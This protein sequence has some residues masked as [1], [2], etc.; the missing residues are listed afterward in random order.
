MV[1]RVECD[2]SGWAFYGF[3]AIK[4][5]SDGLQRLSRDENTQLFEDW[6]RRLSAQADRWHTDGTSWVAWA[7]PSENVALHKPTGWLA[8]DAIRR[9]VQQKAVGPL[10]ADIEA[11]IDTLERA[12]ADWTP[13]QAPTRDHAGNAAR[14]VVMRRHVGRSAQSRPN[15]SATHIKGIHDHP[16]NKW[17]RGAR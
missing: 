12:S 7:W 6:S 3:I 8:P 4:G 10:I 11:V 16:S 5:T 15:G 13:T 9:L 2:E 14:N 17:L 1:L